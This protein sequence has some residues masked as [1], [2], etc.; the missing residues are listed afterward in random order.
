MATGERV[1]VGAMVA[2]GWAVGRATVTAVAM[3]AVGQ[4]AG[5]VGRVAAAV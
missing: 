2:V 4:A 3:A 1:L 5:L